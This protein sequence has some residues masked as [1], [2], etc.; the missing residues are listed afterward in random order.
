MCEEE[1]FPCFFI[2][3]L[4]MCHGTQLD[5]LC[6]RVMSAS[7]QG[8]M[9]VASL[10]DGTAW[11]LVTPQHL[12]ALGMAQPM[13]N[14]EYHAALLDAYRGS[15]NQS[16]AAVPDD[17]YIMQVTIAMLTLYSASRT[18]MHNVHKMV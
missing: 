7:V 2:A 11:A 5:I 6:V 3:N 4:A 9:R 12:Y 10:F 17:G 15:S 13:G 8:V 14:A 18:V 16:F 1:G